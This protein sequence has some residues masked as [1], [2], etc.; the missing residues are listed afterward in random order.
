MLEPRFLEH[1]NYVVVIGERFYSMTFSA[2]RQKGLDRDT[3]E[4]H[5]YYFQLRVLIGYLNV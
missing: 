1:H 2:V 3:I 5:F 4:L